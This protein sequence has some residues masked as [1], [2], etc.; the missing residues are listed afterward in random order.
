[1]SV[2][3]PRLVLAADVLTVALLLLGERVTLRLVVAGSAIL[4]GVLLA[5]MVSRR[6]RG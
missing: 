5:L 1:M 4:C 3:R 6:T 2:A